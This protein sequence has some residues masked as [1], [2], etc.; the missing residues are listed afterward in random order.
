ML[1]YTFI[2]KYSI[3]LTLTNPG[4]STDKKKQFASIK[5]IRHLQLLV[6]HCQSLHKYA[7]NIA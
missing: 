3:S 7:P 4:Y 1:Q 5:I 2:T 6:R